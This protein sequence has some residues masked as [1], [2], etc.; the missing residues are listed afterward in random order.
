MTTGQT[1]TDR[2]PT[3]ET[4]RVRGEAL[5]DKVK[6]LLHEGNV[7]RIT[8]RNDEGHPVIEIPVTAGVVAAVVAPALVAVAAIA[9]LAS[10]WNIEVDRAAVPPQTIDLAGRPADEASAK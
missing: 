4:A 9:A 5:A 6:T 1:T 3:T 2:G 10:H 8:I 7:R